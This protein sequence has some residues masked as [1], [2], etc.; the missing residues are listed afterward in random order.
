M[1]KGNNRRGNK[2]PKKPKQEIPKASAS[3][4]SPSEKTPLVVG[5]KKIK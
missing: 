4:G 5:G 1:A 3:A 2:E